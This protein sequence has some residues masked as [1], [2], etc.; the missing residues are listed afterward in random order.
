MH[1]RSS[2][3]GAGKSKR[4]RTR[5]DFVNSTYTLQVGRAVFRPES[6]G[7]FLL[8]VPDVEGTY[9]IPYIQSSRDLD[10]RAEMHSPGLQKLEVVLQKDEQAVGS[11]TLRREGPALRFADLEYGTYALQV[12]GLGT[13]EDEL[14]SATC[15]PIGLGLVIAALGDSITE[16]Y[17]GEDYSMPELD[18]T[19]AMF[20]PNS[21]SRDGRNF[22]QYAPTTHV[23]KPDVNCMK[24]WMTDLN[25]RLAASL[26][27]PVF[28]ANEGWGGYTAADYVRLVREDENWQTRMAFL[29]PNM[30]LIHL[31]VND[32]RAMRAPRDVVGDIEAVVDV[33]CARYKAKPHRVLLA[34]PCYDYEPG[35]E[36]ILRAYCAAIDDLVSKRGLARGPDFFTAYARDKDRLYGPDPVHPTPEGMRFMAELW[37]ASIVQALVS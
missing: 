31:G 30:W 24:S 29:E 14:F 20:P 25:D 12:R 19:A 11:G 18:L 2:F 26:G 6:G 3:P 13:G 21:V 36:D 35:A 7:G 10:V 22:P 8:T 33:L 28:I 17:F 5:N 32:G 4:G 34:R 27:Y 15:K 9:E 37:S 23:H 16:G 1:T